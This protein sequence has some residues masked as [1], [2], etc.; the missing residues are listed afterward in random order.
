MPRR[1]TNADPAHRPHSA[2]AVWRWA[3]ADRV[4][5]RRRPGPPG[6][7]ARWVEADLGL[8]RS[9]TQRPRLTWIGHSGFLVGLGGASVLVDPVFSDRIGCVYRRSCRPGLTPDQLPPVDAVLVT[10]NHYDHLDAPSIDALGRSVP[11]VVPQGLGRWMADRGRSAIEL[12]WWQ[13]T[14]IGP[15]EITM[16][17]ARHWSR[18]RLADTNR[19]WWGG[20]VVR[21]GGT[22]VY[23]A[24]DTAWFDGFAE[25]GRRLGPL[26]AAMLP[27][28]GYDPA[29]FME[30]QHL[31][32]EQAAE[33]WREL[34]AEVMV[35]MHWGSFRLTDEPLSEPIRRLR[36]WWAEEVG[37]ADGR[38]ADL[39]VGESVVL[40]GPS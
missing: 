25:I 33:A 34:G 10:H 15:L 20:Y 30:E 18:R 23:H 38:L 37:D 26:A 9:S 24:G 28:G 22:G 39:A 27:I 7:A 35:P 16:V 40:G 3:V 32:P 17:P 31:N 5:G 8:V 6:P 36:A 12:G 11:A 29:W 1:Y 19:S 14:R 21:G 4:L 2:A 13:S